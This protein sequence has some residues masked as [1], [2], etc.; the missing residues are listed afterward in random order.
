MKAS[1]SPGSVVRV[2]HYINIY[3][4]STRHSAHPDDSCS[5]QFLDCVRD[6]WVFVDHFLRLSRVLLHLFQDQPHLGVLQDVLDLGVLHGL[7]H[8]LLVRRV[9]THTRH[10]DLHHGLL[11]PPLAPLVIR[12]DLQTV[13][14]RLQRLV[15]VFHEEVARAL[16]AVGFH[17]RRIQLYRLFEILQRVRMCHQLRQR[18]R[19]VAEQFR[20]PGVSLAGLVVLFFGIDKLILFEVVVALFLVLFGELRVHVRLL[21]VLDLVLLAL[22]E[23]CSSLAVVVLSHGLLVVQNSVV[24]LVLF[25][26]AAGESVADLP[27]L[28]EG[29]CALV[30]LVDVV[31]SVHNI[32]QQLFALLEL[33]L[34]EQHR[35]F[36]VVVGEVLVCCNRFI[37]LLNRGVEILRFIQFVSLVLQRIRLFLLRRSV[38]HFHFFHLGLFRLRLLFPW[39]RRERL[40][41]FR[42]IHTL[43]CHEE[44]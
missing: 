30:F 4:P 13:L 27:D 21:F 17:V 44:F 33:F 28:L 7:L 38:V 8:L 1:A 19:S 11:S 43:H 3:S 34:L 32:F 31:P 41:L 9:A 29:G 26:E 23:R 16:P 42:H 36:I 39:L 14:V 37:V 24:V 20:V 25:R 22:R 40:L 2:V 15:V 6:F 10:L 35:R 12:I 18:R 5:H